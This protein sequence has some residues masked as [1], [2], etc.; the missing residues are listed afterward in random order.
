MCDYTHYI[1]ETKYSEMNA[2]E[3]I[4]HGLTQ[5]KFLPDSKFSLHAVVHKY[6]RSGTLNKNTLVNF[7][8]QFCPASWR[9]EITAHA[10]SSLNLLLYQP[11]PTDQQ[12]SRFY[13]ILLFQTVYAYVGHTVHRDLSNCA[14][15]KVSHNPQATR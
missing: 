14:R 7:M 6:M 3:V 11:L 5:L 4:P 12:T 13:A 8:P 9:R 1:I 10:L 2:N 15:K